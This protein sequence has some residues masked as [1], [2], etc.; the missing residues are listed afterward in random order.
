MQQ[1]QV[2]SSPHPQVSTETSRYEEIPVFI[3]GQSL[4]TKASNNQRNYGGCGAPFGSL[5][6]VAF[7]RVYKW[8]SDEMLLEC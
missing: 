6:V 5:K 3:E 2:V 1:M 8:I 7:T 4:Q